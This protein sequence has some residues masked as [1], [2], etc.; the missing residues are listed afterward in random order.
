MNFAIYHQELTEMDEREQEERQREQTEQ[1]R[2]PSGHRQENAS[3]NVESETADPMDVDETPVEQFS[4]TVSAARIEAFERVFGQHM[5]TNRL[6][7]ISIAD[8]ETI[9]NNNGVG[10]SRFSADEIMALLEKLQDDNKV[11]IS[12]G[13]VHII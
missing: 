6:D 13:K 2:T 12:D 11:M 10:A 3:A 1:E 5:R 8:I 4:G 9:V 7:D